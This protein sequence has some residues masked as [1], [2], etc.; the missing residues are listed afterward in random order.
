MVDAAGSTRGER[1]AMAREPS[2]L[3][4]AYVSRM[5]CDPDAVEDILAVS[6]ERN[7]PQGLTG[8]LLHDRRQFFQIIEGER[9]PVGATLLRIADDA[10]HRDLRVLA[11]RPVEFRLFSNW[12]MKSAAF[13]DGRTTIASALADVDMLPTPAERTVALQSFALAIA[14]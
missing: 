11:A 13:T 1:P 2:L 9:A 6:R 5:L 4:V 3:F 12:S 10:R 14:D 7:A 8:L